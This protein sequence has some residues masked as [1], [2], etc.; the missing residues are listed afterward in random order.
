MTNYK[1]MFS[2]IK[3]ANEI[4]IGKI[5]EL[6][7]YFNSNKS[8]FNMGEKEINKYY[9]LK[10]NEKAQAFKNE[11]SKKTEALCAKLF[12]TCEN[13]KESEV[14]KYLK[15]II[16]YYAKVEDGYYDILNTSK[17]EEMSASTFFKCEIMLDY[18]TNNLKNIN[19]LEE[20]FNKK[21]EEIKGKEF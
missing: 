15:D 20:M 21:L 1:E 13:L 3:K 9:N 6:K 17:N 16:N 5:E 18:Y 14:Q 19:S 2:N 4:L 7:D 8:A 11:Y 10:D 12:F